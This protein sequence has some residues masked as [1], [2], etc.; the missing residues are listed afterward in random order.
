MF[1]VER[2]Q[3]NV[4]ARKQKLDEEASKKERQEQIDAENSYKQ[5]IQQLEQKAAADKKMKEEEEYQ[6]GLEEQ[7]KYF[8]MWAN[9]RAAD[10][11][12]KLGELRERCEVTKPTKYSD[13]ARGLANIAT[14]IGEVDSYHNPF[15]Y[16]KK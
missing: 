14:G 11:E 12:S 6:R 5:H 4:I 16:F 2:Q 1:T 7:N 15:S 10:M 3:A 9:K 13:I 8:E